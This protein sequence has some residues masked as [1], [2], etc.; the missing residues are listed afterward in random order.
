MVLIACFFCLYLMMEDT[1]DLRVK[2][3]FT[4][5]TLYLNW[6]TTFP[7]VTVCE[8]YS[9][10]LALRKFTKLYRKYMGTGKRNYW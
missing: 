5:D 2:V 4:P 10:K 7:G 9:T 1:G 6:T 3:N 8:E